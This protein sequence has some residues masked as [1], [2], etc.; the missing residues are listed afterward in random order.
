MNDREE[1]KLENQDANNIKNDLKIEPENVTREINLDELYDGVINNTVV[2]DPVT[3]DEVLLKQKKTNF[4]FIGLILIIFIFLMFYYINNKMRI[5]LTAHDN[6]EKTT[7]KKV[8]TTTAIK[9]KK[10]ILSCTYSSKSDTDSQTVL[11]SAN[12]EN[13]KLLDSVFDYAVI[14]SSDSMSDVIKNLME[15]YEEFYINNASVTGNTTEYEK[16]DKGFTFSMK[17]DYDTSIFE[18]IKMIDG[19][20]VLYVK[21]SSTDTVDSIK[22]SYI[23]KGFTCNMNEKSSLEE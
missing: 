16:N 1:N 23:N 22:Q 18:D 5:G 4:K 21:P 17:T 15:Q 13:N 7:T 3:K 8:V 6:K 9:N 20:T 12:Y 19:K 11:Y 10:G 2:I 14:S